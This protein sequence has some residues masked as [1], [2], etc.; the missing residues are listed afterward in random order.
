MPI[1]FRC[2]TCGKTLRV[3][4]DAIG[5]KARCPDCGTIQEVASGQGHLGT[6]L[7]STPPLNNPRPAYKSGNPFSDLAPATQPTSESENPYAAPLQTGGFA[8]QYANLSHFQRRQL[9]FHR[10]KGLA[11]AMMIVQVIV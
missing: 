10:V 5:K 3:G 4:D 11:L 9:A 8:P 1:I 7:P 6:V 2:I